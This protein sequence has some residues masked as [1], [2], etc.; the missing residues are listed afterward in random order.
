M[1]SSNWHSVELDSITLQPEHRKCE[2]PEERLHQSSRQIEDGIICQ[3]F[4]GI[5]LLIR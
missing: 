5:H 2:T 4:I 1:N 3:L